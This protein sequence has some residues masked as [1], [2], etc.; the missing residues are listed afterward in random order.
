M[1]PLLN[2]FSGLGFVSDLCSLLTAKTTTLC[3]NIS[4][5][6]ASL[7]HRLTAGMF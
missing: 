6:K 2:L 4:E 5:I 1:Y 3:E 7:I